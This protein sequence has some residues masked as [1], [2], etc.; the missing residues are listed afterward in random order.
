MTNSNDYFVN[1]AK[2]ECDKARVHASLKLILT[3]RE[4]GLYD[5]AKGLYPFDTEKLAPD[6]AFQ[7]GPFDN[8]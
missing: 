8:I 7:L 5:K 6:I 1:Y 4:D 3:W 2:F